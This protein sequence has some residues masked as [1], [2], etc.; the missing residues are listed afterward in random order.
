MI[1]EHYNI[2]LSSYND[3]IKSGVKAVDFIHYLSLFDPNNTQVPLTKI[4]LLY[5]IDSN[6]SFD[7]KPFNC[8]KKIAKAIF[9]NL[10]RNEQ[11]E[12]MHY[13]LEN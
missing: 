7:E 5:Y 10:S 13:A 3:L 6:G 4:S 12:V 11:I 2:S 8:H 9:D 1:H